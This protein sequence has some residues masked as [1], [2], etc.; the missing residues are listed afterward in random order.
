MQRF[1]S[2]HD[3]GSQTLLKSARNNFYTTIL[4]IW[5]RTSRN[6]LVL[7]RSEVLGQL[8]NTLTADYKHSAQNRENLPQQVQTQI[9]QE[10]KTFYRFFIAFL[11]CALNSVYFEKKDQSHSL[12]I[13]EINNSEIGSYL[14]VFKAIFH[15]TVRQSTC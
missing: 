8:V 9:S 6:R 13:T 2:E 7:V 10:R 4:L 15:A 3:N 1:D 14:N 11:K 12:S 5:D